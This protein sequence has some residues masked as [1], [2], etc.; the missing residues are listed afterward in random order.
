LL[1][2]RSAMKTVAP[3]GARRVLDRFSSDDLRRFAEGHA[4]AS[5]VG[6]L[7]GCGHARR[8]RAGDD[9][10][11]VVT[12]LEGGASPIDECCGAP[13]AYAG[14]ADRFA[15]QGRRFREAAARF[16]SVVAVDAGCAATLRSHGIVAEHVSELLAR[17]APKLGRLSRP[18][19]EG[20]VRWHDPCQLG[21]GLGVYE[22]PR[23]A[24]TRMLGRAPD[25]FERSRQDARCSG[26]GG[27]L[28]V[29]MPT[30]SRAIAEERL[31]D[32][33]RS[34]GGTIVTACASSALSFSRS[35]ANV[36]DLVT[37]ARQALE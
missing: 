9:A 4:A 18:L 32:H 22:A 14:D 20:P 34:G 33:E 16:R 8:G 15:E 17:H 1:E 29:T 12:K 13:L 27:L 21:R 11:A 3:E 30:T 31:A 25:E 26:A 35:G 23:S 19:L 2:A 5:D 37:L 24:L 10:L 6:V 7:V 36:V 28:P